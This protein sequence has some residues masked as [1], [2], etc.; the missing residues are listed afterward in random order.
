M[1]IEPAVESDIDA[2]VDL[3]NLAFRGK[4]EYQSWNIEHFITG[5]RIDAEAIRDDIEEDYVDLLVHRDPE[6]EEILATVRLEPSGGGLWHLGMLSIT[7]RLQTQKLGRRMVEV[8]E[9][10]IRQRGGRVIR[11]SVVNARDTLIAWYERRGY[12]QT[13]ETM[14]FPDENAR[15][16]RPLRDDL[17]FVMLEKV[18]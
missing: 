6:T 10:F 17:C 14:P 18:L 2:I 12:R 8:A 11:L 9:D 13:G 16:G 5:P 1:K 4:G 3:V 7:P 15:F